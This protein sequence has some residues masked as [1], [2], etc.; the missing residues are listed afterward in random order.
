MHKEMKQLLLISFT[1]LALTACGD[2]KSGT[3]GHEQFVDSTNVLKTD[4]GAACNITFG[5]ITFDRAVNGADSLVSVEEGNTLRFRA[6]EKADFFCDPDEKISNNTAPILLKEID[7]TKPFTLTAKVTPGFNATGTF[8]AGVLYVYANDTFW[9]K[10]CFEQDERGNYRVV[11]VRTQGTS[12]DNN[13]DIISQGTVYLRIFSDTR[14][15]ASYYSL[16]KRNWVM[17]RLYKNNYPDRVFIGISNQCPQDKSSYSLF[18]ELTL[19]T[20]HVDNIRMGN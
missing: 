4:V 7:N 9:Q 18:E 20:D 17:V 2:R 3:V 12:D 6:N 8:N 10:L 13:H 19:T 15:M 16:D 1:A 14:T 11:T 5:D